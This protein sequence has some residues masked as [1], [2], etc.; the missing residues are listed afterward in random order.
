MPLLLI[1]F[2]LV[3]EPSVMIL[4]A[5]DQDE[6]P[7]HSE[8]QAPSPLLLA[9]PNIPILDLQSYAT[10]SNNYCKCAHQEQMKLVPH[11]QRWLY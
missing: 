6:M 2:E 7:F 4:I 3:I 1:I 5:V 10:S 8:L 11:Y 9:I